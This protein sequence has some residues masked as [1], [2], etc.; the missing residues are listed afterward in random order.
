MTMLV[1]TKVFS[2]ITKQRFS[3]KLPVFTTASEI[4]QK[5]DLF[6]EYQ[7]EIYLCEW[8]EQNNAILSFFS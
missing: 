6:I 1:Q 2:F 7:H 8:N 3:N 5:Q 4:P